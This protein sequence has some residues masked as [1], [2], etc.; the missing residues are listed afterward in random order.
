M[1]G[2]TA[3]ASGTGARLLAAALALPGVHAAWA[4]DAP[5][6]ATAAIKVL[7]YR[8]SQPG[9]D[10]VKVL[11]P[12]FSLVLPL[13]S[14]WSTAATLMT[15]SISGASPAYHTSGLTDLHDFRRAADLSVSRYFDHATVTLGTSV[16]SESDY[17]SR[18]VSA[19]ASWS[20][21][22][23]NTTWTAGLGGISDRINPGNRIVQDEHKRS[24]DLLL[25]LTQVLGTHDI[26][27]AN[28]GYARGRGYYSDPYKVF[29]K[30]PR[31]RHHQTALLRWN[32]HFETS[33]GT[34]RSSWRWYGDTFGI[35]SQTLSFDYVQPLPAGWTLTPLLRLYTQGAA[36]FYVPADP[37]TE[38]FPPNPP[39]GATYYSEDQR[40]SAFGARTLGLKVA[41][42]IGAD[43]L[44]DIKVE[45]YVQ[46]GSWQW[47]GNG[48]TDLQPFH[49][50][51]IQVGLSRRF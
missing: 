12:A 35:R 1:A 18:G 34:L 9:A 33:G 48:S 38:P 37:S 42:Q 47:S 26:V 15:D 17:F 5:E 24:T 36:D 49:V 7:D 32:H 11:A 2:S 50:R 39:A 8:E 28:L 4:D 10:R 3:S 21:E 23:R 41:K 43:W 29:D 31:E 19:Q 16:S 22:D 25:G 20:T 51:S 46:R 13:G 6:Q 30:R 45:R 40:L 27:Q 44:A 14:H